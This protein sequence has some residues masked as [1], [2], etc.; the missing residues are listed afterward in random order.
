MIIKR[1]KYYKNLEYRAA[2]AVGLQHFSNDGYLKLSTKDTS[3][4]SKDDLVS[5]NQAYRSPYLQFGYQK[6]DIDD[7]RCFSLVLHT[8]LHDECIINKIF[9]K[10]EV[11]YLFDRTMKTMLKMKPVMF[12]DFEFLF[13]HSH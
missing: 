7:A 4:T 3:K 8:R 10:Y 1:D 2:R 13:L 11:Y 9:S 12:Q 5:F 6:Q